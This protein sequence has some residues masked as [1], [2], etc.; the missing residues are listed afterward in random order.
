MSVL[1]KIREN[2]GLVIVIIAISLGVFILTDLFRGLGGGRGGDN[3]LGR[4]A[5]EAVD[6]QAYSN[7]I[8]AI[9]S[10]VQ[11]EITPDLEVEIQN[12]A[13]N[14]VVNEM[15]L[16]SEFDQLGLVIS[17]DELSQM[18]LGPWVS[19]R[20]Q[21]DAAF[22]DA[23]GR[24]SPD[25]VRKRLAIADGIDMNDANTSDG[26]RQYKAYMNR[27]TQE[28]MKNR[29]Q[30]RYSQ[31]LYHSV[32]AT[33]NEVRRRHA[34]EN[35]RINIS[36]VGIPYSSISDDQV[37]V[38][39]ADYQ[40]VYNKRKKQYERNAVEATISY[41]IFN[42]VPSKADSAE[43]R[44]VLTQ[45][46]K[47]FQAEDSASVLQF[48]VTNTDAAGIDTTYKPLNQLPAAVSEGVAQFGT[49]TVFGPALD[50]DN[51]TYAI[52]RVTGVRE[53]EKP[54]VKARHILVT[55]NGTTAEDTVKARTRANVIRNM[56][57]KDNFA[58]VAQDSSKDFLTQGLGGDLGWITEGQFGPGS[59]DFDKKLSE[60]SVG[61]FYVAQSARGFHVVELE[62]KSFKQYQVAPI[63]RTILPGNATRETANQLAN[64]FAAVASSTGSLDSAA[65]EFPTVA[66]LTSQPLNPGSGTLAG[67]K[68][69]RPVVV[70]ALRGEAG[71]MIG[72]VI[73][74]DN[75]FVVA[76]VIS[77][78]EKGY[79]PLEEV[80]DRLRPIVYNQKKAEVIRQKIA[81]AGQ[82]LNAVAAA[83][84]SG[85][86]V[87]TAGN[88]SF[89]ADPNQPI[90]G[91][92]S[93]HL[94]IGAAFS[95]QQ[96][97]TSQPING[98]GG[99]YMVRVETI[100]PAPAL[101]EAM[102]PGTKL[103][104]TMAKR[105]A[106]FQKYFTALIKSADVQDNR[107]MRE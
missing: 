91:I 5:G 61:S 13:W 3:S 75:A 16:N 99:V 40:A 22:Q 26:A 1:S 98:N 48:A 89:F 79:L 95:L 25:T 37:T 62:D 83:S 33:T 27:V 24:Y 78:S 20:I 18:F 80:K 76:K 47:N 90:A 100:Q 55:I 105:Q 30:E 101:E 9:R 87:Q 66:V 58:Q 46:A 65:R 42:I 51:G 39:D 50:R 104:Q 32:F 53:S 21:Q 67:V 17:D 38:T 15:L 81:S 93:E 44:K 4:V 69:A 45:L 94:V 64:Q 7:Q 31:L 72:E 29:L 86:S 85:A 35:T 60:Q 88:L 107:Y 54:V 59:E 82:D 36:Y 77:K 56:V 34:D 103:Q 23:Q 73:P 11:Q 70:A 6:P 10:T 8:D 74:T 84:G 12:A 57:N 96:G 19:M 92:G 52:Y 68:G 28:I 49:D 14:Q 41:A 106:N 97:Q 2:V 63:T 71:K 43:K 102:L